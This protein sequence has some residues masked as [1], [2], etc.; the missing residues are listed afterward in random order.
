MYIHLT[1]LRLLMQRS[2]YLGWPKFGREHALA[3]AGGGGRL[4]KD[5]RGQVRPRRQG[6]AQPVRF[7]HHSQMK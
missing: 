6:S 7:E 5:D 2:C 4:E 3:G 1:V